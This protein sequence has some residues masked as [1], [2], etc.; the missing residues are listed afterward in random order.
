[1]IVA[2]LIGKL[3]SNI[4]HESIHGPTMLILVS[5][6]SALLLPLVP[7][8]YPSCS[9][10]SFIF[11][12]II[13]RWWYVLCRSMT[14]SEISSIRKLYNYLISV[15]VFLPI[16]TTG[17]RSTVSGNRS[18]ISYPI[19]SSLTVATVAFLLE[20]AIVVYP[21]TIRAIFPLR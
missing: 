2:P 1:M 17:V 12:I 8:Q 20:D 16:F 21:F 14:G 18:I 4:F 5:P 19:M 6:H 3:E 10:Y 11:I 7:P 13:M 15:H 9:A